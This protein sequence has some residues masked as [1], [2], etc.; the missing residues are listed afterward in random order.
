MIGRS[1]SRDVKPW[2][3]HIGASSGL[4]SA[5]CTAY[6][7]GRLST[8]DKSRRE[9]KSASQVNTS[10]TAR[11]RNIWPDPA[12][13]AELA[14]AAQDTCIRLI[15]PLFTSIISLSRLL[16]LRLGDSPPLLH[17][18]ILCHPPSPTHI[19]ISLLGS[20]PPRCLTLPTGLG[21]GIP[22]E[23]VRGFGGAFRLGI[24]VCLAGGEL[25]RCY[26]R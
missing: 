26:G 10:A 13:A 11:S 4:A 8:S 24:F 23:F 19:P 21:P 15:R 22:C 1:W 18:D 6:R 5:L 2:R 16:L 20:S 7:R 12:D 17:P 9:T 14:N 25:L 3:R